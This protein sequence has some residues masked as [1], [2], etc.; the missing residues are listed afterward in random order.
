MGGKWINFPLQWG[1]C[2]N[3]IKTCFLVF[4]FLSLHEK[5][6]E[7]M[8]TYQCHPIP[9][10]IFCSPFF[11]SP[12]RLEMLPPNI[13]AGRNILRVLA[14]LPGRR[15]YWILAVW[16]FWCCACAQ[17]IKN[18]YHTNQRNKNNIKKKQ[19]KT[20]GQ[21]LQSDLLVLAGKSKVK[22]GPWG[23]LRMEHWGIYS[24][25]VLDF[26]SSLT[27]GWKI[28]RCSAQCAQWSYIS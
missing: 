15:W 21:H 17:L 18:K 25:W 22:T 3:K 9:I 2:K 10:S 16:Q 13:C 8:D 23:S 28:V 5:W 24:L 12:H 11:S 7:I 1:E 26:L 4:L 20:H 14:V 19:P 6:M 27:L